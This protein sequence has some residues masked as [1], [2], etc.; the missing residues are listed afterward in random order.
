MLKKLVVFFI[1]VALVVGAVAPALPAQAAP[2]PIKILL[3]GKTLVT[4]V[5]P[6]MQNGRTLVPF[7]AIFEALGAEVD[8]DA[9][10]DTVYGFKGPVFVILNPGKTKAWVT[11]KEVTLDVGPVIMNARTLVP[12]RFVAEALGEEVSYVE[13]TNTVVITTT[14]DIPLPKAT[15]GEEFKTIYSGEVST[16][17]YLSANN[18]IDQGVGANVVD[19]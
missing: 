19:A 4:E 3:N 7:R 15:V 18:Q 6:Q 9:A 16:M 14:P 8:Y 10:T 17:N 1:M 5:A 13:A 11:G 12:L 2:L